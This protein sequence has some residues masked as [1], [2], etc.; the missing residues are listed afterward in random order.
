MLD[1]VDADRCRRSGSTTPPRIFIRVDL[2][3]PFSPTRPITSPGAT[4]R[5]DVVERHDAGIGLADAD[6]ARGTARSSAAI[7][8]SRRRRGEYAAESHGEPAKPASSCA[9]LL[10]SC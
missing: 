4:A 2:P 5:L 7:A 3:A 8:E 1:A 6:R 10:R 9:G